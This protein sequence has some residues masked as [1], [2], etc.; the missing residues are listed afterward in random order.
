M[1]KELVILR[2]C[3]SSGKSFI[4][5]KIAGKTGRAFSSDEYHT[6]PKTGKYN[7]KLENAAA[8]HKWN[9]DRALDAVLKGITP[10]VIDN[11]HIQ[12]WELIPLQPIIL[13]AQKRGYFIRI[14]EPNPDWYFWDT[15]FDVEILFERNKKTHNVPK[16]IIQKMVDNWEPNITIKDILNGE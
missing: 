10:V 16:E 14:E 5:K 6:D 2:G 12:L 1:K 15:A 7:W 13:E 11:T 3:P 4:A 9:R 8:G